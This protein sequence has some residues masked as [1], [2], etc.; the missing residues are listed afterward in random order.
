MENS[1]MRKRDR[2]SGVQL[3]LCLEAATPLGPHVGE[4]A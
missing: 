2:P 4:G 1:L 3:G